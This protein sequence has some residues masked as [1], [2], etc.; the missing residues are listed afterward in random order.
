MTESTLKVI[1]YPLDGHAYLLTLEGADSTTSAPVGGDPEHTFFG[2]I[3]AT[4]YNVTVTYFSD[5]ST[6]SYKNEFRTSMCISIYMVKSFY[7]KCYSQI[8]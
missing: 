2:L 8:L 4:E 3:P 6:F 5:T 1:W 7:T